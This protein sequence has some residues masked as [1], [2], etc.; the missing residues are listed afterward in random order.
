M[1]LLKKTILFLLV[2][3]TPFS[4]FEGRAGKYFL[5][6]HTKIKETIENIRGDFTSLFIEAV[7]S[8]KT[9]P[10]EEMIFQS[11]RS[12]MDYYLF[13][14]TASYATFENPRL[15]AAFKSQ[16]TALSRKISVSLNSKNFKRHLDTVVEWGKVMGK[17]APYCSLSPDE[18]I[19]HF[20][21]FLAQSLGVV[22]D[23]FN[24]THLRHSQWRMVVELLLNQEDF[25]LGTLRVELNNPMLSREDIEFPIWVTRI[26]KGQ[27][28]NIY[29]VFV[30]LKKEKK[31]VAFAL[32]VATNAAH[33][34]ETVK[35][36][37]TLF[38]AHRDDPQLVPVIS[39]AEVKTERGNVAAYSS[40]LLNT[41]E[42]NYLHLGHPLMQNRDFPPGRWVLNSV[43][44]YYGFPLLDETQ[45]GEVVSQI[46]EWLTVYFDPEAKTMIGRFCANAGDAN[47]E[48]SAIDS[49]TNHSRMLQIKGSEK[50][51]LRRI[52]WRGTCRNITPLEFLDFLLSLDWIEPDPNSRCIAPLLHAHYGDSG[53]TF[54]ESILNGIAQGLVRGMKKKYGERGG[55][56]AIEWLKEYQAEFRLNPRRFKSFFAFD[57]IERMMEVVTR[58]LRLTSTLDVE[59]SL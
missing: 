31:W 41:S 52:A 48:L 33:M 46:V 50:I 36:E 5:A 17:R 29:A 49:D 15:A 58:L 8:E 39:L 24:D 19:F 30:K 11:T 34:S 22:P 20:D 4:S 47:F 37:F 59:T 55:A 6:P 14:L 12:V 28:E 56:V 23:G 40:R 7:L 57:S 13:I 53:R 27:V 35:E 1:L 2:L 43:I 38:A 25:L 54:G 32:V 42:L 26:Q 21:S 18:N 10:L 9:E 16:L 51:R 44:P 3:L 45:A